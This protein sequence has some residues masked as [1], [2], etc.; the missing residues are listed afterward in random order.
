[1]K[2]AKRKISQEIIKYI[3]D[4]LEAGLSEEQVKKALVDAGHHEDKVHD[5]YFG[6]ALFNP[7]KSPR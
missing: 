7:S 4:A 2:M 6:P 3:E 1:M 5:Q